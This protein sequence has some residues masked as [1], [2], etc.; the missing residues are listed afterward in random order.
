MKFSREAKQRSISR[1]HLVTNWMIRHQGT[2]VQRKPG[3]DTATSS[4]ESLPKACYHRW[5]LER[6]I[7]S[8]IH[9]IRRPL[10]V[11]SITYKVVPLKRSVLFQLKPIKIRCIDVPDCVSPCSTLQQTPVQPSHSYVG[12]TT[13]ESNKRN[14]FLSPDILFVEVQTFAE[15]RLLWD[16]HE[17]NPVYN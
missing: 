4:Y 15:L 3:S 6:K 7:E 17:L 11:W 12:D 16:G 14:W 10:L 1:M 13:T 5:L 2:V 8:F 9:R